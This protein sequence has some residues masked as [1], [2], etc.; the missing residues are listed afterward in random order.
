M[1]IFKIIVP[2]SYFILV[3][4]WAIILVVY[5]RYRKQEL[6]SGSVKLMLLI[7]TFDAFRTFFESFYFGIRETSRLGFL[8]DS[9]FSLLSQPH[10]L[11][12][13]KLLNIL[14]GI[15]I[16]SV[17]LRKLIPAIARD[18]KNKTEEHEFI[19]KVIDGVNDPVMVID[20]DY[21]ITLMN[22]TVRSVL[23]KACCADILNPKCY[24]VSHQRNTPCDGNQHPCPL[25]QVIKS[26]AAV[27]VVHNHQS[28]EGEDQ[29]VELAATPLKDAQGEVYAI[30]ESGH[31]IT[32]LL[33][34]QNNLRSHV[35][36]LDHQAHHDA[37][38]NLP[39]RLLF[40]DRLRQ[41]IKQA[42]RLQ[43]QVAILFVDLDRFKEINDSL[44]HRVGDIVLKEVAE[45]L[46]SCL[47]A[48]DTVA[49]LGGDEF[50][51]VLSGILDTN[52]IAD[53]AENILKQMSEYVVVGEHQL[54]VTTSIG[55][56]LYPEDGNTPDT[57]LKNADAAMYKAKDEGR[58]TYRYYT[59]DMTQRAFEHIL[60]ETSLRQALQNNELVIYYQPQVNSNTNKIIG[61]EALVRWEHKELGLIPPA[62]FI[63]LAEDTGLIIPLGEEV[64][65]L[66][67]AQI[68]K[69]KKQFPETGRLSINLSVKQL[70]TEHFVTTV[71][72]ILK[73]N[74]CQP[75]W[76]EFEVTEGYIM[77][78][79]EK[80]VKTLQR[81]QD[82]GIEIS[83]DDFGTGYSSLSYLKR[84]P[85]HKLKIDQSFV[86]DITVDDDDKSIVISI[87]SLANNMKLDLLAEGVETEEQQKFLQIE[88]CNVIQG[89]LYSRPVPADELTVMLGKESLAE[90]TIAI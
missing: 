35:Q 52:V 84:L 4:L 57:L 15:A 73:E 21:H 44:G 50:T 60:M 38:T 68:V 13:P 8:P 27:T 23:D 71:K 6:V 82:M 90:D 74:N 30:I 51:I 2:S 1:D 19:Q 53:I 29:F 88:G 41:A 66:A 10:F 89:F 33:N 17:L 40:T 58:N 43:Q 25:R 5:F 55:I 80:A 76:L 86:R 64:L 9:L 3:I 37:L 63:P 47:R 39:N 18:H 81:F 24:E 28:T 59:E 72:N 32:A 77:K 65:R 61:M 46:K 11:F 42:K 78:D 45:R 85:I 56:S 26:K 34:T 22:E 54:Y 14:V 62:K 75:E 36:E 67:T 70:Q 49:R 7:L 20:K 79:A 83:I 48:S 12:I 87:I 31:D 69:W 16:L